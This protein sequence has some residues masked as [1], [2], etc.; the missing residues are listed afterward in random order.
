[1]RAVIFKIAEREYA[2]GID[3]VREVT[4][5]KKIVPV[6]DA[7][8][9]VEG[10][11]SLRGKVV[12]LVNLRKKLGFERKEL[13]RTM[14]IIVS[15][16]EG[17]IIGMIVDGVSEVTDIHGESVTAPDDAL[18]EAAYLAGIAKIDNRIILIAD[19]EKLLSSEDKAGIDSVRAKVE[20][21]KK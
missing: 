19:A 7:A 2:L 14:R 1:M 5:M 11:V 17:R 20:V 3:Q 9:F 16:A 18:K 12:T 15:E 4:R 10:V 6:P 21:R 8:D 13:D